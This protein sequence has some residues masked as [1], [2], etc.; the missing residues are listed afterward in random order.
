LEPPR[1]GV[2]GWVSDKKN[3]AAAT[4]RQNLL[5]V[6]E[7]LGAVLVATGAGCTWGRW[8][9]DDD[10]SA[11]AKKIAQ[12]SMQ[13][14]RSPHTHTNP[15]TMSRQAHQPRTHHPS[16]RYSHKPACPSPSPR[17][18]AP[19][20]V[21]GHG[22]Q[23]DAHIDGEQEPAHEG[24]QGPQVDDEGHG[25]EQRVLAVGAPNLQTTLA[26]L[27]HGV[28]ADGWDGRRHCRVSTAGKVPNRTRK[29]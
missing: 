21:H 9:G 26:Q 11:S 8:E 12:G 28:G 6:G 17:T 18:T 15:H 27:V 19:E 14:P 23:A 7:H 13:G 20:Q 3:A 29:Q 1:K 4:H 25:D 10:R 22:H 16:A 24:Q 5:R 2:P